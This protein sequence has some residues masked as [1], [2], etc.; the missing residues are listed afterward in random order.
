MMQKKAYAWMYIKLSRIRVVCSE[1]WGMK[2]L[3]NETVSFHSEMVIIKVEL[4]TR[5]VI[6]LF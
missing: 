1:S 2:W 6:N 5:S 4:E 3:R